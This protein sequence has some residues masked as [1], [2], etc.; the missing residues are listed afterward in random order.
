MDL[1]VGI[2]SVR[3]Q[4]ICLAMCVTLRNV[5][6][7]ALR[8]YFRFSTLHCFPRLKI[9]LFQR[10]TCPIPRPVASWGR[11]RQTTKPCDSPGHRPPGRCNWQSC[12][13][14]LRDMVHQGGATGSR[15]VWF[16]DMTFLICW[17]SSLVCSSLLQL[18]WTCCS[19]TSSI[20]SEQWCFALGR[21]PFVWP[22][23]P[24][25]WLYPGRVTVELVNNTGSILSVLCITSSWG[26]DSSCPLTDHSHYSNHRWP[27]IIVDHSD[28]F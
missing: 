10:F 8:F 7:V 3:T 26:M 4:C 15:A 22:R 18:A 25:A 9:S 21:G 14:I 1:N 20:L 5:V 27:L 24:G 2:I 11:T 28:H 6:E 12:R 13:V 19:R 17:M 23:G 16:S